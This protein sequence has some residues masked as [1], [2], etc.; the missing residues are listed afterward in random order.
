MSIISPINCQHECIVLSD[1]VNFYE[2]QCNIAKRHYGALST[3]S[4]MTY[5]GTNV[6]T[7]SEYPN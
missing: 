4:G 6:D 3:M 2:V 5:K 7:K 1:T